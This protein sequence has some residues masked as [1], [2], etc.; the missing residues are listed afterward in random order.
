[1]QV[2]LQS[3]SK[4]EISDVTFLPFINLDPSNMS[5][6]YSSLKYARSECDKIKQHTCFITFDQPLYAKATDIVASSSND[7]LK[8]TVVLLGGFHT[9]MS[10]LG[11]VGYIMSGSGIEELWATTYAKNAVAHMITGHAYSRALRAHNLTQVALSLLIL[12][13]DNAF[14]DDEKQKILEIYNQF[15]KGEISEV[16]I[17]QS[18]LIDKLVKTLSETLQIKEETSRTARLWVQYFKLVNWKL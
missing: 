2:S 16:E 6:V 4:Y 13:N 7:D 3:E 18:S 8:D 12:E 5:C 17:N 1:M 11:A 10:F 15:K 9:I 14:N